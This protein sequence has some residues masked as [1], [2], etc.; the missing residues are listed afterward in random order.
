M[1][2]LDQ[3]LTAVQDVKSD[4]KELRRDTGE[5]KLATVAALARVE[6]QVKNNASTADEAKKEAR[7]ASGVI[8]MIVSGVVVG[9][10][11]VSGLL[12]K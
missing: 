12:A 1:A 8:A 10:A 3:V 5:F 9:L 6:E 7:K 4:V 2:E 11:K